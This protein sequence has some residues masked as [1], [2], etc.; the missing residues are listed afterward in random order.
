MEVYRE[1]FD[2]KL[3]EDME[4]LFG[5]LNLMFGMVFLKISGN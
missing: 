2:Y 3:E 1:S 5:L 4:V